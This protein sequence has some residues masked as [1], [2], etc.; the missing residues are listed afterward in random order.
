MSLTSQ[1]P[2]SGRGQNRCSYVATG[3]IMTNEWCLLHG[4][5]LDLHPLAETPN[6]VSCYE[7]LP[8]DN[9]GR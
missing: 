5:A 6:R 7:H 2:G 3:R 9:K 4:R 1:I 8:I